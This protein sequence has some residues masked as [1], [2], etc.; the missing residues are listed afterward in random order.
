MVKTKA[1]I[2]KIVREYVREVSKDY[3]V[4]QVILFGSYATGRATDASDIDL[5]IVSPDFKG[6]REMEILQY[7][8]RKAMK[9][10]S[11]LEV[12]AFYPEELKDPDRRSFPYQVK[13]Y[14]I[15]MA[16]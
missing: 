1:Q 2:K 16:A 10:D 11:Y 5:A 12:L 6:K 15:S 4:T 13:K 3:R 9:V 14:G 8:S 7:L